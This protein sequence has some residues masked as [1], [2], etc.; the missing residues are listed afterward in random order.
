M[1]KPGSILVALLTPM[2]RNGEV[3]PGAA[4]EHALW[5]SAQGV[6]GFFVC[7]T[8]GE[9]VLLED[10]EVV[11]ITRSVVNATNKRLF[12]TTQVGRPSTAAS[13]RLLQRAIDAGADAVTAVTPYYYEL[14]ES[15]LVAHY[16]ALI[17]AAKE[18]PV[19]AYV[20][21]RR[22]G[23]DLSPD[24]VR[25]LADIG[26]A[27]IKDS[28]R[29]SERHQEYRRIASS[30][31]ARSFEV[32]MGTDGLALEA[33]RDRSTGVVSAIANLAPELFVRLRTACMEERMDEA[34]A[35]QSE[36]DVLRE[37]LQRGNMIANLKSRLANLLVARGSSYPSD[38][39]PPLGFTP[40]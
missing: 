39:R 16:R 11:A 2:L 23:N 24:L 20:I 21:P 7:G 33:F 29:S 32:Y 38:V 1:R 10:D 28:T 8:T 4:R 34:R 30:D 26:L 15:Q 18:R 40:Q 22:A 37:S 13:I 27:G 14:D 36:I 35:L 6:D 12:V 9:G 19:Y 3:D 5:L 17:V 25:R 31:A